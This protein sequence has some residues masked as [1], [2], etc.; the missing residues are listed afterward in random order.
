MEVHCGYFGNAK[1]SSG[2]GAMLDGGAVV[3]VHPI[4]SHTMRIIERHFSDQEECPSI[5]LVNLRPTPNVSSNLAQMEQIVQIAHEKEANIIIFPELCV[6]GYVWD[7]SQDTAD[8][9]VKELLAEGENSRVAATIDAIRDSLKENGR[10]PEYVFY[11]NARRKDGH[12]YNSTFILHPGL[13][14]QDEEYIYDKIFLTPI[15]Q[16]FFQQGRDRRLSIRTKWG[17]FGFLVCYDLCFV[18]LARKY[19][20][21]DHVDAIVTMA[22]W[23]SEAVREYPRMNVMTDHYYG[24][25]WDVMNSS[26]AAYNQVWTL[27]ANAVGPHEVSGHYFWGGSGIWA[28]SG[29]PVIQASNITPELV[30]VHHV[31]IKGQRL[32]ERDDF[33][34]QIDFSRFY[35]D[36]HEDDSHPLYLT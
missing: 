7:E 11:N 29:M 24:F 15:E 17:G 9:A 5:L 23:R 25:L 1:Q 20:F 36:I 28:P 6:T 19:A 26:K 27:G 8:L 30:L 16:R 2:D 33:D 14:Y 34:Y 18:E 13:D 21:Q 3:S 22:H 35:K 4:E 31:D 10:G 32:R 12:L